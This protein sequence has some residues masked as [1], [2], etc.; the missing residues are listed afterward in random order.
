[1]VWRGVDAVVSARSPRL[2]PRNLQR[3]P[4][5]RRVAMV[6]AASPAADGP[7]ALPAA[8][9]AAAGE[10]AQLVVAAAVAAGAAPPRRGAG[11]PAVLQHHPAPL[12]ADHAG[13]DDGVEGQD[14]EEGARAVQTGVHPGPHSTDQEGV[15][16]LVAAAAAVL[17]GASWRQAGRPEEVQVDEQEDPHDGQH[18]SLGAAHA[19]HLPR[20]IVIVIVV[21]I[22]IIKNHH[23]HHHHH[24]G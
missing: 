2:G 20:I 15:A 14:D 23:H 3:V 13:D 8:E 18:P 1:M 11:G 17:G 10:A 6:A 16:L 19:A 7:V 4:A 24:D 22:I 21:V 12:G 9:A 5:R